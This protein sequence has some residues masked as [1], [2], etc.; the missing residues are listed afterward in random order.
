MSSNEN[1]DPR[2]KVEL[3]NLENFYQIKDRHGEII[4]YEKADGRELFNHYRHNMTNYDEVL[5]E[6]R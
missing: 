2:E 4:D 5:N 1:I 6:V 3:A